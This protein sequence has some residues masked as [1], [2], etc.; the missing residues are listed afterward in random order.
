[1]G[2][3]NL[4][5]RE[6]K[7]KRD[8]KRK[9]D[10]RDVINRVL[11]VCEGS[12]TEPNYFNELIGFYKIRS[13]NVVVDGSSDSAPSSVLKYAKK[14]QKE[15]EK[16]GNPFDEIYCVFDKDMH[17][18]Y[19]K[20]VD[21]ISRI[22]P[23]GIFKACVSVPCFEMWLI[24]HY[25]YNDKPYHK[26]G[27]KSVGDLVLDDLKKIYP[28]YE[29]GMSGIFLAHENK[30]EDAIKNAQALLDANQKTQTDNPSTYVHELVVALR[31]L[32]RN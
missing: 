8:L 22:R 11:I 28:S 1:M 12:E 5:R 24:L 6:A 13:A 17:P 7:R 2:S 27:K 19:Q 9:L 16:K 32:K 4:F 29:K 10:N 14:K 23:K 25:K 26:K 21:E 31:K 20:T 30:I 18:C 3:D 15:E